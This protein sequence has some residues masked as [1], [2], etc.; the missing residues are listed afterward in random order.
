MRIKVLSLQLAVVVVLAGLW[1]L[2]AIHGTLPDIY[3]SRPTRIIAAT[4][5]GFSNG[6]LTSALGDTLYETVVGFVI[7]SVL[8]VLGRVELDW[9]TW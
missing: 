5:D 3:V 7:A 4:W 9:G 8:G 2:L 6:T 1:Q